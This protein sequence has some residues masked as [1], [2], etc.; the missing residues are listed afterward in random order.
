MR[1]AFRSQRRPRA[2][3]RVRAADPSSVDCL[4]RDAPAG[5]CQAL[6]TLTSERPTFHYSRGKLFTAK[7]SQQVLPFLECKPTKQHVIINLAARAPSLLYSKVKLRILARSRIL[8]IRSPALLDSLR[9]D[10]RRRAALRVLSL[11]TLCARVRLRLFVVVVVVVVP[12]LVGVAPC[13]PLLVSLVG[14]PVLA[15][16]RRAS[17]RGSIPEAGRSVLRVWQ[18]ACCEIR[19]APPSVCTLVRSCSLVDASD[20][21]V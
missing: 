10:L 6:S 16:S 11:S 21:D 15:M 12:P 2:R 20:R 14:C 13:A 9:Q 18:A 4:V 1:R 7:G 17:R 5:P 3:V 8:Y 19:A